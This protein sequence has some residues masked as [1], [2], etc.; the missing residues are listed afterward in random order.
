MD[1]A[2]GRRNHAEAPECLLAPA[3]ELVALAIAL[4]LDFGVALDCA[5]APE[6]VHLHGVVDHEVNRNQRIDLAGVTTQALHCRSHGSQ[7]HDG[8]HSGK[9]LQ[10]DARGLER[11]LPGR[12]RLGAPLGERCHIALRH[13]RAVAVPQQSLQQHFDRERQAG[14]GAVAGLFQ[15]I[16]AIDH[17]AAAGGL[18]GGSCS[19]SVLSFVHC[20]SATPAYYNNAEP[21]RMAVPVSRPGQFF[22]M[23][24]LFEASGDRGIERFVICDFCSQQFDSSFHLTL[25]MADTGKCVTGAEGIGRPGDRLIW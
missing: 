1:N 10:D 8:G 19:K 25:P 18:D 11:N 6:E 16:Q 22:S 4:K 15:T 5:G 17:G 12:R 20:S 13:Q 2:G 23:G 21:R 3:Q 9:I 24:V 14:H 7:V